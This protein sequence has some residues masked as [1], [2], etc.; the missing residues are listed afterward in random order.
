MSFMPFIL[1]RSPTAKL[2]RSIDARDST[3][4]ILRQ[5]KE[6]VL[7]DIQVLPYGYLE[8]ALRRVEAALMQAKTEEEDEL[9]QV[10]RMSALRR[11]QRVHL[12][13]RP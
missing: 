10:I 6:I 9:L 13:N 5:I 12:E 1:D 7:R 8:Q 3:V 4:E 2:I 11:I